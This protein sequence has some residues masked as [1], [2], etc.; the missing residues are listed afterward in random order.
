MFPIPR[1]RWKWKFAQMPVYAD[2]Q[3]ACVQ[4]PLLLTLSNFSLLF[5]MQAGWRGRT[6]LLSPTPKTQLPLQRD[7]VL[8]FSWV[9]LNLYH[10]LPL[11]GLLS[12]HRFSLFT[13]KKG[14]NSIFVFIY[15]KKTCSCCGIDV[16]VRAQLSSVGS[17]LPLYGSRGSNSGLAAG[18]Y[19]LSY[20]TCPRGSLSVLSQS[21]LK[22]FFFF[23]INNLF[24]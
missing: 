24:I 16:E 14:F 9:K 8:F 13:Y 12:S 6:P 17:F 19:L 3:R 5:D 2:T 22:F 4:G 20:L 23:I 7:F 15:G 10:C 1:Q 21:I 18:L 11:L